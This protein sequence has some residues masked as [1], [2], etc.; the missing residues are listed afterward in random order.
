MV[1]EIIATDQRLNIF[2]SAWRADT[3]EVVV[4]ITARDQSAREAARVLLCDE[5]KADW[6]QGWRPL[7]LGDAVIE[8]R[9]ER[10]TQ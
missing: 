8:I 3:E 5:A 6:A 2:A 10:L 9:P 4:L 7:A 1:R